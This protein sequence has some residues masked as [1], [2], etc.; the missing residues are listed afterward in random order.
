MKV[1]K[2]SRT[3]PNQEID[4]NKLG[5]YDEILHDS[6]VYGG[7]VAYFKTEKMQG[8]VSI[9]SCGRMISVG[10]KGEQQAFK[11]LEKA[12]NFLTEKGIT[13]PVSLKP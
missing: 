7:R 2:Y 4:F 12:M 3:S 5:R 13:K 11:E 6:D 8:R 10:T 1:T 9:F